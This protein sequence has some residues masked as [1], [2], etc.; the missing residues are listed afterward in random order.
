MCVTHICAQIFIWINI[1]IASKSAAMCCGVGMP[2]GVA[3][4]V[5]VRWEG[6]MPP[7]G[8]QCPF[9]PRCR[10]SGGNSNAFPAAQLWQM[11]R[12]EFCFTHSDLTFCSCRCAH[13]NRL[14]RR[15]FSACK[16]KKNVPVSVEM[17]CSSARLK[18][19]EWDYGLCLRQACCHCSKWRGSPEREKLPERRCV[20]RWVPL[21]CRSRPFP[22]SGVNI[23]RLIGVTCLGAA[24]KGLMKDVITISANLLH[25]TVFII[26]YT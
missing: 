17:I 9:A 24:G 22:F 26:I 25:W 23:C 5:R 13:F 19:T 4:W 12:R 20:W 1:V 14:S 7:F 15:I 2:P 6:A 3:F 16:E 21:T 8:L 10:G 11:L 18:L